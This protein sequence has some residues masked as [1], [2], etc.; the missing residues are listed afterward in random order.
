MNTERN[1]KKEDSK[2]ERKQMNRKL[3]IHSANF[4][5]VTELNWVLDYR[6]ANL[7]SSYQIASD[8]NRKFIKDKHYDVDSHTEL[9]SIDTMK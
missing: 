2:H 7:V 4:L 5:N 9:C 8:S 1:Q 3:E 6:N